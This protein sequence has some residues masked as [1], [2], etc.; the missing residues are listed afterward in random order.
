LQSLLNQ[1]PTL[2]PSK[3][4]AGIGIGSHI[5]QQLFEELDAVYSAPQ[6]LKHVR[7]PLCYVWQFGNFSD[8]NPWFIYILKKSL[9]PYKPEKLFSYE[10]LTTEDKA[11]F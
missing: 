9:E 7:H 4:N 6:P 5:F 3:V 2:E 8:T 1:D 11:C 10:T